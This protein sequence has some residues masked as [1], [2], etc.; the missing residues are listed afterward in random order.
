[1]PEGDT[2]FRTARTLDRALGG[3]T[4]TAF[5]TQLS[6]LSSL[7]VDGAVVG[8]LISRV[9]SRGKHL[10]IWFGDDLALRSHLRMHGSWHIYRPG[11]RWRVRSGDVR[12]QIHTAEWL[13]LGVNL[14]EAEWLTARQVARHPRLTSLGPDL[15][16]DDVDRVAI[17]AR[18]AEQCDI[19]I[20]EVLL[21]QRV[22][23]GIGNV[24]KSEVLFAC[25]IHPATLVRE[26]GPSDIQRIVDV[27]VKYLRANVAERGAPLG[28]MTTGRLNP[29][30][31]LWVYDRA[32]QPCFRCGGPIQS[33]ATGPDARRTYWCDACQRVR[34]ST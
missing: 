24:F 32:G 7:P 10:L 14:P 19:P 11:E 15:L 25:R 29:D 9:E 6:Q 5:E 13:A 23:A 1:V 31:P 34:P 8:R 17:A 22:V 33:A 27:S 3:H 28:R 18:I 2:L 12:V 21:N 20:A 4:I 16:A 26:L 30:E